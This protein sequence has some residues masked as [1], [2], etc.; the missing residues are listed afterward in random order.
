MYIKC[1]DDRREFFECKEG[2]HLEETL[3][4]HIE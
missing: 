2:I 3:K 1:A 4:M